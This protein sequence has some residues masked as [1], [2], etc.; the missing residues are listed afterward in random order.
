MW[1]FSLKLIKKKKIR[2]YVI[3]IVQTKNEMQKIWFSCQSERSHIDSCKRDR[4]TLWRLGTS[5]NTPWKKWNVKDIPNSSR[6]AIKGIKYL[7]KEVNQGQRANDQREYG[8]AANDNNHGGHRGKEGAQE[9][10]DCGWKNL[11]D[12]VNVLGEAVDD[13]A[14]G[15]GIKERLGSVKFVVQQGLMQLAWALD[16]PQSQ[17]KG[18][19]HDQ[20]ACVRETRGGGQCHYTTHTC[21][22]CLR[23]G[24]LREQESTVLT[25]NTHICS[26]G[27]F[28]QKPAVLL[29]VF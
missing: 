27:R 4:I 24:A 18:G 1:P 3:L 16:F 19:K 20:D 14:Y 12:H 15:S 5:S 6:A 17:S 28:T 25:T 9:H 8:S 7:H 2:Y 23:D 11:I 13:P 21:R 26:T 29:L 22:G 10:E